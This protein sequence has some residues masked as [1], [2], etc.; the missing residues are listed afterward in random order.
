MFFRPLDEQKGE[1]EQ[2][3]PTVRDRCGPG[4]SQRPPPW[5]PARDPDRDSWIFFD[6][7]FALEPRR[8]SFAGPSPACRVLP[9]SP[10]ESTDPP[11]VSNLAPRGHLQE[12]L[13]S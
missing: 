2:Q 5:R 3:H 4:T 8:L 9:G 1:D 7:H 6:Y 10:I 11:G 13:M 12:W